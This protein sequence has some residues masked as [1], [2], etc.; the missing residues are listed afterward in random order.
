MVLATLTLLLSVV[1]GL[2]GC[3]GGGGGGGGSSRFELVTAYAESGPTLPWDE[4]FLN[5]RVILQFSTNVDPASVTPDTVQIRLRDS[6]FTIPAAGDLVVRGN[7]VEFVP[8]LP[9]RVDLSDAGLAR[10]TTYRVFVPGGSST[11]N[12]VRSTNGSKLGASFVVTFRARNREPFLIDPVPGPPSI[13]TVAI[14]LNGDGQF[15][16]D[17]RPETQN[18]EEFPDLAAV[19]LL[20]NSPVGLARAPLAIGF[21]ISEPLSPASVFEDFEGDGK[22][23]HVQLFDPGSNTCIPS[24]VELFQ[25]FLPAENRY[26]TLIKLTPRT[27]LPAST[28][29]QARVL[30]GI[31]DGATPPFELESYSAIIATRG[32]PL[33]LIDALIEDFDDRANAGPSS[34]AGWDAGDSNVLVAGLGVGGTGVNGSLTIASMETRTLNTANN[35]GYFNFT[36]LTIEPEGVLVLLGPNPARL[37]VQGNADIRGSILADGQGGFA[38]A[39]RQGTVV[40]RGGDPGPGGG[41]GG[42]ANEPPTISFTENQMQRG[43]D[44]A[45][46]VPGG[47]GQGGLIGRIQSAGGAGAGH[48]TAA[49]APPGLNPAMPGSAYG[50]PELA[51]ILGG[52]GGGGGGDGSNGNVLPEDENTGGGGG[53]G[54][55]AVLFSV[56]GNLSLVGRLSVDGGRGGDGGQDRGAVIAGAGGGG[57]SGGSCKIQAANI[58]PINAGTARFSA[59]GGDRGRAGGGA[60][61]NFGSAGASGR[62]RIEVLDRNM[63]G[64]P[65]EVV[66]APGVA[67][68]DPLPTLD[69]LGDDTLGKSFAISRFLDTGTVRNRFFFDG[70]DAMTGLVR[71]GPDVQDIQVPG[72]LPSGTSI[73]VLFQGVPG[74]VDDPRIPDVAAA[75]PFTSQISDLNGLQFIRY[76]IEFDVGTDI[77]NARL[78]VVTFFQIRFEFDIL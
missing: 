17:G 66:L 43:K 68:I 67:L 32:G 59:V 30:E 31:V 35:E 26:F 21:F 71:I 47:G 37:F 61:G 58:A 12:T 34:S 63:D 41:K 39:R 14:D 33:T 75:G 64:T 77:L 56:G 19:P 78:P 3:G 16:A 54:G 49:S 50:D 29:I 23:D 55:G 2:P 11:G 42:N 36:N 15:D 72:G 76:R 20:A 62:L 46:V 65:D 22:I 57:G 8:R 5:E 13:T 45:S 52:S 60:G 10:N 40:V 25:N 38:G 6:L 44:G 74:S 9:T 53:G 1:G 24:N 73:R 69:V 70:S 28:D 48:A 51:V 18:S 4:F 7:L 27:T